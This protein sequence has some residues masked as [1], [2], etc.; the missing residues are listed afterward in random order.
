MARVVIKNK[1]S[2]RTIKTHYRARYWVNKGR[3]YI[4]DQGA[5]KGSKAIASYDLKSVTW[6]SYPE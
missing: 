5:A 3:V 2:G 1:R 4:F 6:K